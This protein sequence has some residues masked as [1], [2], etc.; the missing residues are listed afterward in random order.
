MKKITGIILM[1]FFVLS[2]CFA[3]S[4]LKMF[5]LDK[6]RVSA[7]FNLGGVAPT[8]IPPQIRRI[9]NFSPVY[10]FSFELEVPLLYINK[11]WSLHTGLGLESRSMKAGAYVE[12]FRGEI[13][14]ENTVFQ[15]IV[16][17]FTGSVESTFHN[18]YL[19]LPL[20]AYYIHNEKW[21]FLGGL[22]ISKTVHRRF[23]GGVQDA[24]IRIG[25]PTSE[26]IA[27]PRGSFDLSNQI[28]KTDIGVH[29]GSDYTIDKRWAVKGMMN[30][31]LSNV[32]DAP[33]E[34]IPVK[35]HNIFL[36][37][38]LVYSFSMP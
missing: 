13:D 7:G 5:K 9:N 23:E 20:R 1:T 2:G 24:Y 18:W 25:L 34:N 8:Y 30:Y 37:T 3:Q 35:L 31:G 29:V 19:S 26:K 11:Q 21:S 32:I 12:N 38:S 17:Y 16:G 15:D 28:R 36:N 10:P 4:D 33:F 22:S 27:V 6:L 14:L